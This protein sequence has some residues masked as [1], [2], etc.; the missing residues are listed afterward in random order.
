[1]GHYD[2]QL[3]CPKASLPF[4][5]QTIS[6]FSR[7]LHSVW[8]GAEPADPNPAK[9]LNMGLS[10]CLKLS[11]YLG[12]VLGWSN[13]P[14]RAELSVSTAGV[15]L[16]H[17]YPCLEPDSTTVPQPNSEQYHTETDTPLMLL[18]NLWD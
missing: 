17:G 14:C 6:S 2:L 11:M 4:F 18:Q 5:G 10:T 13:D 12:V 7:A 15:M 9:H 1:M 16:R 3:A 8:Q